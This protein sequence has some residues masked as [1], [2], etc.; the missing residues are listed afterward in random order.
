MV[1]ESQCKHSD[2]LY[3]TEK[4][5]KP[6]IY[7]QPFMTIG[8]VGILEHLK[9]MGYETFEGL[10]DESYDSD[11][12]WKGRTNHVSLETKRIFDNFDKID[13]VKYE[14][15]TKYA[16]KIVEGVDKL[17]KWSESL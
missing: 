9:G 15:I 5:Y 14:E 4:I 13:W 11:E 12:N 3:C 6:I 8:P 7:G 10:F 16:P 2:V 1:T 17:K